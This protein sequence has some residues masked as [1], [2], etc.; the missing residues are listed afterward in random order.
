[1]AANSP[2]PNRPMPICNGVCASAHNNV[3]VPRPKKKNSN[4][5]FPAPAISQPTGWN[6]K[7]AERDEARGC[8]RDQFRIAHTPFVTEYQR[9][10]G[11]EDQHAQVVEQM[12][13]IQKQVVKSQMTHTLLSTGE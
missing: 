6:G 8:V 11:C 5:A 7:Q 12:T 2:M 1:M 9:S 4:Q 3:Q 10:H 13:D